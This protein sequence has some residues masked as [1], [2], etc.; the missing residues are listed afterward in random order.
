MYVC[1]RSRAGIWCEGRGRGGG[2]GWVKGR[3]GVGMEEF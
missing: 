3:G 2:V 1:V